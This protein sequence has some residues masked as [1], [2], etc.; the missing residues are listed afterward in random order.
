MKKLKHRYPLGELVIKKSWNLQSS[1]N[2]PMKARVVVVNVQCSLR[3][4]GNR[5]TV[6]NKGLFIALSTVHNLRNSMHPNKISSKK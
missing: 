5:N 3:R 4:A 1:D 6:E 2:E